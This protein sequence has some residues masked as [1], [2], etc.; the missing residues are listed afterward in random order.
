MKIKLDENIGKR[1][2]EILE[3]AGHEVLTVADQ[4][5]CGSSDDSLIAVCAKEGRCL[6][7]LD[8]GFS[9]PLLFSPAKHSGIAV[10]RL[11]SKANRIDLLT[12]LANLIR[13]LDQSSIAGK[14][15][16]VE[17]HRVREYRPDDEPLY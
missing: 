16:I 17:R 15:W 4:K 9:N 6:V 5:M 3:A 7:T 13:I 10:L 11:P 1:G 2:K 8:L 14:L 12:A